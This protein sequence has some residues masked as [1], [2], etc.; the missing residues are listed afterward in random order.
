MLQV[1]CFFL[2]YTAIPL[3]LVLI[4]Y[5]PLVQ[6]EEV[7]LKSKCMDIHQF[8]IHNNCILT[9]LMPR[10]VPRNFWFFLYLNFN[11]RQKVRHNE[12]T[13]QLIS[14]SAKVLFKAKFIEMYSG[15]QM[16]LKFCEHILFS[17]LTTSPLQV[18][19]QEP[20]FTHQLVQVHCSV[21]DNVR[22]ACQIFFYYRIHHQ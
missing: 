18:V 20:N 10:R 7:G 9:T 3:V 1:L 19:L 15:Q 6:W 2:S 12:Y 16:W 4:L 5:P 8:K 11:A 13:K 22:K 21:R 17:D 14:T